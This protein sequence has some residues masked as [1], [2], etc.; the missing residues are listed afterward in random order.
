[1]GTFVAMPIAFLMITMAY[2]QER[3]AVPVNMAP[4]APPAY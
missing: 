3:K 2:E 1:V 4:P